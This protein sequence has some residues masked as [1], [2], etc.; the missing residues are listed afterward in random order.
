MKEQKQDTIK[1][2]NAMQEKKRQAILIDADT[3][4]SEEAV[5]E[6]AEL[7]SACDMELTDIWYQR[8]KEIKHLS[9]I[10]SGKA[11]EFTHTLQQL[12]IDIVIFRQPLTSLQSGYLSETWGIPVIDRS[13]LIIEIFEQRAHTQEAKLQVR[14][15]K[16]A[17][18]MSRLIGK[19]K[20]LGRQSGGRNK[21][22]G[23]KQLELN[24]RLLKQRI[25][26]CD[27]KLSDLKKQHGL[28]YDRRKK[29]QIPVVALIG[30]TNA[31][32][33]TVLNALLAQEK[34]PKQKHVYARD[35]LFATLDTAMRKISLPYAPDIIVVDT[36]GFVSDL[37]HELIDAFHATLSEVQHA[38][39]LL[40]IIDH[41]SPLRHR[42]QKA[43]LMTLE[44][45]RAEAIPIID[46]FNKCDL[47][48]IDY[49]KVQNNAVYISAFDTAGIKLLNEQIAETLF[50]CKEA[51]SFQIPYDKSHIIAAVRSLLELK[52]YE[53]H[54]SYVI[55]SGLMRKKL[56]SYYANYVKF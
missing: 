34:I 51:V 40:H 38:D 46:V 24:R 27:R 2:V 47:S 10:G 28:Q 44:T 8:I 55:L 25:K 7:I 54:T 13:E 45:L 3:E 16:T 19:T 15:A 20:S 36:V 22:S 23:E 5:Q 18:Q 9:Y 21:G 1:T 4:I 12:H 52:A 53:N 26:D 48:D 43:T 17:K 29:Q 37:P 14:K 31:G 32:K 49:P 41:H 35:Q 42:Q 6:T 33:S 11:E 30:Y 39:L 56:I 50:G